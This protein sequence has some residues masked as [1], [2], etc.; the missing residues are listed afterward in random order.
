M[1]VDHQGRQFK[2][3]RVSITAACNY[4]CTYCVPN[5]KKLVAAQNELTTDQLVRAV[6]LLISTV[7]IEKLRITGGEP[8]ISPKFDSFLQ[9][10]STLGLQD[11]SITTNAQFLEKKAKVILDSGIRRIN[12]SLD[13]LNPLAFSKIARSGDLKTVLSGIDSMLDAGITV[14]I[15]MVPLRSSNKDQ[16][17]DMLQYCLDRNIELRF[18]ELMNM[19]HLQHSNIYHSEFIGQKEILDIIGANYEFARTGSAFDS[20]SVRYRVLSNNLVS[21][22]EKGIKNETG[23]GAFGI[24]ANE[25]EPFCRTCTRLRLSSNGYLYGCLSNSRR[26]GIHHLLE[27]EDNQAISQLQAV[28]SSALKDKQDRQFVGEYT[29]MKFIGG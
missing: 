3:L 12:V 10:V 15:N 5:G 16:I 19:G 14:K 27:M 13:T 28:L 4:A 24:I 18:I 23:L 8:L 1:I 17:L 20:T 9:G 11:I 7:G 21:G 26:H 6:R 25:S 29:V 2:S 22:P